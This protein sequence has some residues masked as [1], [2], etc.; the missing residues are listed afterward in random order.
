LA[1]YSETDILT[2]H[3]MGKSSIPKLKTALT[4]A[5]LDFKKK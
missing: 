4:E 3:G 5:G 2:L 1:K